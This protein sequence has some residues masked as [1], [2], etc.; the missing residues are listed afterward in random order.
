[1]VEEEGVAMVVVVANAVHE[2]EEVTVVLQTLHH[3][4][5]GVI[6]VH[7]YDYP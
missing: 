6:D 5:E 3:P 1:M 2:V 4:V 7:N